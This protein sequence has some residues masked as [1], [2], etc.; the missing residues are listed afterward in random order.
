MTWQTLFSTRV[1]LCS[2]RAS[3][4]PLVSCLAVVSG[5]GVVCAPGRARVVSSTSVK[6]LFVVQFYYTVAHDAALLL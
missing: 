2:R 3:P 1:L 6:A 5:A 4:Y